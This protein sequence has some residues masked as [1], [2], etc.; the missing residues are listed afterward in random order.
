LP[1]QCLEIES[2]GLRLA[3][4]ENGRRIDRACA[5]RPRRPSSP[6]PPSG[7]ASKSGPK[8]FILAVPPR[9]P[10]PRPARRAVQS[11]YVHYRIVA[12]L[13]IPPRSQ[14][15][16]EF[17]SAQ[18][19]GNCIRKR[20][21]GPLVPSR[22]RFTS[23]REVAIETGCGRWKVGHRSTVAPRS[24]SPERTRTGSAGRGGKRGVGRLRIGRRGYRSRIACA[25]CKQAPIKR[26]TSG[27]GSTGAVDAAAGLPKRCHRVR[28]GHRAPVTRSCS[29]RARATP[30]SSALRLTACGSNDVAHDISGGWPCTPV[31]RSAR[32][33]EPIETGRSR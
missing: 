27:R 33:R 18:V 1:S 20:L 28:W 10:R 9:A 15:R 29:H 22:I 32:T 21:R 26:P 31:H 2:W 30:A 19:A 17:R 16:D 6:T 12:G 8:P 7:L 14:Y 13:S 3:H 11:M 24:G 23:P 4:T 25:L 5:L